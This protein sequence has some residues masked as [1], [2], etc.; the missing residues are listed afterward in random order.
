MQM[1][2]QRGFTI[3][4]LLI[5]VA[6]IGLI[7]SILIPNLIDALQKARQKRSMTDVRGIGV[8]WMSWVT[9]QNGAASAGA[10]K[11]YSTVGMTPV[12]Y[13]ALFAYLRPSE[14]FFYAQE[15]PR[16][17]A[18]GFD[19]SFR[20]GGSGT[21]ID[22]IMVCAPCRDGVLTRCNMTTIPVAAFVAS[23]Y[24]EDIV[25]ADGYFVRF[26]GDTKQ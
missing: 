25:W 2:K 22:R 14:D 3:I 20:M 21:E 4:E 8:A 19:Y 1:K 16:F 23:D 12:T 10:S 18:W 17:D 26:P 24:N 9:D 13:E 6:V 11:T 15:V 5:V 7:A